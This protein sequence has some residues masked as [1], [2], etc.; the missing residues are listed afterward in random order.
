[1]TEKQLQINFCLN[2][3]NNFYYLKD[4]GRCVNDVTKKIKTP[5][6]KK[7]EEIQ[8]HKNPSGGKHSDHVSQLLLVKGIKL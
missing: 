6:P 1:M 4:S 5:P 3:F 8:Q 2:L 7:K